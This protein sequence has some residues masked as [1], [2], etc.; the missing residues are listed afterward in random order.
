[1]VVPFEYTVTSTSSA[2]VGIV[3]VEV[4]TLHKE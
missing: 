4:E 3:T 1:M 2:A